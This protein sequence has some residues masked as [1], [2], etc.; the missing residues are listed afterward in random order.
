MMLLMAGEDRVFQ[1]QEFA[2]LAG[3]TVKALHHYDRLELLRP[4]RTA[5]G[6]RVYRESDLTILEQIIALQFLGLPLKQ[7]REVL[8]RTERLPEALRVQRLALEE[9]RALIAR[10]IEAIRKAESALAGGAAADAELLKP[11]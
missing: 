7:I 4:S 9:K 11:I 1:I 2:D 10:T 8:A 6:Y 5:A 3:V